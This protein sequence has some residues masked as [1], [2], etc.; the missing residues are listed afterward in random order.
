ME[1]ACEQNRFMN[2]QDGKPDM[3]RAPHMPAFSLHSI[4]LAFAQHTQSQSKCAGKNPCM[5]VGHNCQ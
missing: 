2:K 4:Y 1:K 3:V 5:L